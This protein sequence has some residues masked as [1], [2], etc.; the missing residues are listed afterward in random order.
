MKLLVIG[1]SVFDFINDSK[2]IKESAGGI[3]YTISALNRLKKD[4]DEIFLCSQ[5]DDESYKYFKF[6]AIIFNFISVTES[7]YE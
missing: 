7:T 2:S 3:H 6:P 1:H 5:I 4:D